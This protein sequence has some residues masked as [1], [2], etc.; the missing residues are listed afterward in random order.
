MTYGEHYWPDSKWDVPVPP[1][2]PKSGFTWEADGILDLD[3]R[4]VA[5]FSFLGG[6]AS[7]PL[8]PY[9]IIPVVR[10]HTG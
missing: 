3:A 10:A 6:S 1:I 9:R 5:F 2:A 7:E 4:G 8:R